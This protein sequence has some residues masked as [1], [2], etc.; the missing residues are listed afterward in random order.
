MNGVT[1]PQAQAQYAGVQV[2]LE[3]LP[4]AMAAM[5]MQDDGHLL[6]LLDPDAPAS[7]LRSDLNSILGHL[8]LTGIIEDI[9]EAS[10][11]PD[12]A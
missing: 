11:G 10:D 4:G 7:R 6:L 8:I 5:A 9:P 12:P 2:E 1:T 3:K